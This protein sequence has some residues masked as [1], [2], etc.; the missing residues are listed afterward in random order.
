VL[1]DFLH[2]KSSSLQDAQC[3]R[4]NASCNALRY[5]ID[6]WDRDRKNGRPFRSL[7]YQL[8]ALQSG[9]QVYVFKVQRG[10]VRD[11]HANAGPLC[12][13]ARELLR[14]CAFRASLDGRFRARNIL[15]EKVLALVR[16]FLT[17]LG[18][19]SLVGSDEAIRSPR[20]IFVG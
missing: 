5:N 20:S 17:I 9:D 14:R 18:G 11:G 15:I 1:G 6:V 4:A 2:V 12:S 8:S 13:L 7:K 10:L 3:R 19:G 16:A